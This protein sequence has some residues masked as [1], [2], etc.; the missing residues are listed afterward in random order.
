[1]ARG[2]TLVCSQGTWTGDGQ[3]AY[4][5]AWLRN[6]VVIPGT[7]TNTYVVGAADGGQTLA[8]EV[9]ASY[10]GS[11]SA[12]SPFVIVPS[13][14]VITVLSVSTSPTEMTLSLGC[15]GLD[16]QRCRG[17]L[18]VTVVEKRL[19]GTVVG[20]AT[21]AGK[22]VAAIGTHG[23]S[24][25]ARHTATIHIALAHKVARWLKRFKKVPAL[26][27]VS[28]TTAGGTGTVASLHLKIHRPK[29]NRHG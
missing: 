18:T 29:G 10:Y 24:I 5:F 27:T 20:F 14:P 19:G 1:M 12:A 22:Q 7:S 17:Q 6:G 3:L 2:Q 15:R 13:Y 26:L 9:T 21:R 11:T 28:Q 23:Y 8:C 4:A 16:G 25:R